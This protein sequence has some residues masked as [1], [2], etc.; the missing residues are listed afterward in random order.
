MGDDGRPARRRLSRVLSDDSDS[1]SDDDMADVAQSPT[2][3]PTATS[4]SSRAPVRRVLKRGR[5]DNSGSESESESGSGSE[6]GSSSGSGS[7]SSSASSPSSASSSESS[8]SSDNSN[9]SSDEDEDTA[10]VATRTRPRAAAGPGRRRRVLDTVKSE[11]S[12][13]EEE[14]EEDDDDVD[15]DDDDD[16]DF[17]GD[18]E[19]E[20]R[21]ATRRPVRRQQAPARQGRRGVTAAARV[22]PR[23]VSPA[24]Q[25]AAGVMANIATPTHYTEREKRIDK[26]LSVRGTG[27]E[28]CLFVKWVDVSYKHCEWVRRAAWDRDHFVRMKIMRALHKFEQEPPTY[29][30]D[31]EDDLP[32]ESDY[33]IP[34]R[35]V[36]S[37]VVPV[38]PLLRAKQQEEGNPGATPA[39]TMT[40]YLVKWKSLMYSMCTWESE[41][42][43]DDD[44]L[45]ADYRRRSAP[46]SAEEL[47]AARRAVKHPTPARR[48][49]AAQW[50]PIT[51]I[52]EGFYNGMEL[53]PYQ[54]EGLNWL[55]RCWREGR[56]SILADEMGLGKT[57][58]TVAT[59]EWLH[60]QEHLHGPFLIVAP[61][62]TLQHWRRESET[63]TSCNTVVYHGSAVDRE[64]IRRLEWPL[65]G[66]AATPGGP[67]AFDTLITSFEMLMADAA[68]LSKIHWAFLAIDEA[69]KL[70][71]N[72]SKTLAAVK[73]L[74]YDHILL[75]T[76]TPFQNQTSE[77][78][79]LLNL[80]DPATY[81]SFDAFQ[82]EYGERTDAATVQKIQGILRPI[83]LRRLKGDVEKSIAAKE[84]TIVEVELTVLQKQY[85][86]AIYEHNIAFLR[87]GCKSS[88]APSLLNVVMELR[89]CC[90]HPY[91]IKGV[92]EAAT[93][94][95]APAEQTEQLVRASGKLVFIDKLLPKLKASGHQVLIFSQMVRVLDILEDYLNSR[96]YTYERL[97]GHVRGNE[98]QG[99]IDRFC[100]PDSDRFVFLLCTR[101]GGLGINLQVADTVIIFDSDWNPQND[102]QAQARCHRIGQKK[103]VKVYRLITR[104]TYERFMFD[105]ASK[106]LGLDQAILSTTT[107]KTKSTNDDDNGGAS[108]ASSS[109]SSSSSSNNNNNNK[110]LTT[111]EIDSLLKYGA[112][113]VLG[114][115][116][117]AAQKFV[118]ADIDQILERST[119]VRQDAG[120]NNSTFSKATFVTDEAAPDLDLDDPEFWK[121][122]LPD[123]KAPE[124]LYIEPRERKVVQ[125]FDPGLLGDDDDSDDGGDSGDSD[126]SGDDDDE[127]RTGTSEWCGA[128]KK[129]FRVALLALGWGQWDRIKEAARIPRW[130]VDEIESFARTYLCKCL[131]HLT[132]KNKQNQYVK[133]ICGL[134]LSQNEDWMADKI[135]LHSSLLIEP[136][137]QPV[138]QQQEQQ[139]QPAAAAGGAQEQEHV[140]QMTD[141]PAAAAPS[142]VRVYDDSTEFAAPKWVAFIERNW[143]KNL[144][145]LTVMSTLRSMV[146]SAKAEQ[147]DMMEDVPLLNDPPAP[148]WGI[149]EDRDLIVGFV[150]H[151][152]ANYDAMLDDH[153]LVFHRRFDD[154]E[155]TAMKDE[156]AKEQEEKKEQEGE[157]VESGAKAPVWPPNKLLTRRLQRVYKFILTCQ[158]NKR[159]LLDKGEEK[160]KRRVEYVATWSKRERQDLLRVVMQLGFPTE[161]DAPYPVTWEMIR[162]KA[163]LRKKTPEYVEQ[164]LT[165]L[166]KRCREVD[167]AQKKN[168]ASGTPSAP[169]VEPAG[170]EGTSADAAVKPENNEAKNGAAAAAG[171]GEKTEED[172]KDATQDP[173]ND[174]KTSSCT[175]LLQRLDL[176]SLLRKS[177]MTLSVENRE[178]VVRSLHRVVALPKW[179]DQKKHDTALV[180]G[181]LKHGFGKWDDIVTDPELEF[182]SILQKV[183]AKQEDEDS[184]SGQ[185]KDESVKQEADVAVETPAL[186]PAKDESVAAPMTAPDAAVSPVASQT[187]NDDAAPAESETEAKKEQSVMELIDMPRDIILLRRLESIAHTAQN[188]QGLIERYWKKH[189]KK[190]NS[191]SSS[192]SSNSSSSST[193]KKKKKEESGSENES[194]HKSSRHRHHSHSRS[195]SGSSKREHKHKHRS[196]EEKSES[197]ERRERRKEKKEKRKKEKLEKKAK[198]KAKKAA[199]AAAAAAA[200]V[201]PGS[202]DGV[203]AGGNSSDNDFEGDA[204]P[205]GGV[206]LTIKLGKRSKKAPRTEEEL[207]EI[208]EKK[209]QEREQRRQER[210]REKE[211]KKQEKAEAKRLVKE[212]RARAREAR[213]ERKRQEALLTPE[214]KALRLR[215]RREEKLRRKNEERA[216]VELV[217]AHAPQSKAPRLAPDGLPS[218]SSSSDVALGGLYADDRAAPAVLPFPGSAPRSDEDGSHSSGNSGSSSGSTVAGVPVA[219]P[220]LPLCLA[221]FMVLAF[222][223]VD[224]TKPRSTWEREPPAGYRSTR[225]YASFIDPTVQCTYTCRVDADHGVARY[226]VVPSDDPTRRLA[227]YSLDVLMTEL[228]TAIARAREDALHSGVARERLHCGPAGDAILSGSD[229][230]GL[231]HPAVQAA[232][233]AHVHNAYLAAAAAASGP[234]GAGGAGHTPLA[235]PGGAPARSYIILPQLAPSLTHPRPHATHAAHA[236]PAG[237]AAPYATFT[238]STSTTSTTSINNSNAFAVMFTPHPAAQ[239]QQPPPPP[240]P[241]TLPPLRTLLSAMPPPAPSQQP[242]QQQPQ[243]Q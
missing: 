80:I 61:L 183:R 136:K 202:V 55:V 94:G 99:A 218:S 116:D 66:C 224:T 177:F 121:K 34:E 175:R 157:E 69:H 62:A 152:F 70:K 234:A 229:F 179:W 154:S 43:I 211:R 73:Q 192:S 216:A 38:P 168:V 178:I 184:E 188:S 213:R 171:E 117:D 2:S 60:R 142:T 120:G 237:D 160:E 124:T 101:A 173:I 110:A 193:E 30:G 7:G 151:G 182:F 112:Y 47:A 111:K 145:R 185:A 72:T 161:S 37:A 28:Q 119:V 115:G 228:H 140:E 114:E 159:R 77:L 1:A 238:R 27:D 201:V 74:T 163:G 21:G 126:D 100:R 49:V 241:P 46:R 58:Q 83:L 204:A 135:P 138:Q 96:G 127:T 239:Q 9:S 52:P 221:Q 186:E 71:N 217:L 156:P 63:W 225:R 88:N 81:A 75:L 42:D 92:E 176:I 205:G 18:S 214:E 144:N 54:L 26:V 197:K 10:V 137:Q 82:H 13:S 44:A 200:L 90:N 12:S 194:D 91:L 196:R 79:P 106:K 65:R 56:N 181:V 240:V 133:A 6:C 86:R 98:R 165:L 29:T 67:F 203:D 189:G 230:F 87:K 198:K 22:P 191:N 220:Q 125:R 210:E 41:D 134:D 16:D 180:Y 8:S 128:E 187:G 97:D 5:D 174:I 24:A 102:L 48:G 23:E 170:G 109:S 155:E 147:H 64:L 25:A 108:V 40:L 153:D 68:V 143:L 172:K 169:P 209:R 76:G 84:E 166:I 232:L 14:D 95:L 113:G 167:A 122:V 212:E 223:H 146:D 15:D 141:T 50:T 45:V 158:R 51:S 162:D 20:E 150:K 215:L 235:V 219:E 3:S 222:G 78:W 104:N 227:S 139:Q 19:E 206:K 130:S 199:A 190:S 89:K 243:Q 195:S 57:A 129:R 105:T 131:A 231:S 4:A 85:Y 59:I 32:F 207:R 31:P 164:F 33:V 148:W 107:A 233:R 226:V 236:A 103:D 36:T 17:T 11:S 132:D 118:E 123:V 39:T 149:D 35:V 208:A 93:Q 53:R 242:Q